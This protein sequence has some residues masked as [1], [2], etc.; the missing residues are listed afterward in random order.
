MLQWQ[1]EL[2]PDKNRYVDTEKILTQKMSLDR[3]GGG[4]GD[5]FMVLGTGPGI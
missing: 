2:Y 3:G 4:G 5:H 1:H